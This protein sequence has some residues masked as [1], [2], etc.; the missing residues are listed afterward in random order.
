MEL[1]KLAGKRFSSISAIAYE[2]SDGLDGELEWATFALLGDVGAIL[3]RPFI[4]RFVDKLP[5]ALD[6]RRKWRPGRSAEVRV[7][8]TMLHRAMLVYFADHRS[9]FQFLQE[10]AEF[11]VLSS[12][13]FSLE[14]WFEDG[15]YGDFPQA[16][17]IFRTR[18]G[19]SS[20]HTTRP[21]R[22]GWYKGEPNLEFGVHESDA[23]RD[24][25]PITRLEARV[26][27]AGLARELGVFHVGWIP[28][29]QVKTAL[30]EIRET[31]VA[32]R[33]SL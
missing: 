4:P 32:R 27:I 10:E 20:V 5:R 9:S 12:V 24:L 18:A 21:P 22:G 2:D 31:L 28:V 15:R 25:S 26:G 23:A 17:T 33:T 29:E 19:K 8:F 13:G 11:G 16:T 7:A 30:G 1:S 14:E 3:L 6:A